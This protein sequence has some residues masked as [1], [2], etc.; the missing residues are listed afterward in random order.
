METWKSYATAQENK[1]SL[2]RANAAIAIAINA[3][4]LLMALSLEDYN[5]PL[6]GCS[7]ITLDP[8]SLE[9]E[10]IHLDF[11]QHIFWVVNCLYCL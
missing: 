3:D 4:F 6:G 1:L 9:R 10:G 5:Q 2:N 11:H 7:L 8:S